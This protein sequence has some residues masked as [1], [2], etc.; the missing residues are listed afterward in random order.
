MCEVHV[1]VM[2]AQE[3][4]IDSL[5]AQVANYEKMNLVYKE[6]IADYEARMKAVSDMIPALFM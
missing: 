3:K 4:L 2:Q 6:L 1:K 5:Y